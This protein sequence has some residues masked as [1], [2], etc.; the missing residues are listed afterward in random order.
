MIQTDLCSYLEV[1]VARVT[2]TTLI[3]SH[4]N[5]PQ[6]T[7][8]SSTCSRT[9]VNSCV[10]TVNCATLQ[11]ALCIS[12]GGK[13]HDA[14]AVAC[15]V[16]EVLYEDVS[17]MSHVLMVTLHRSVTAKLILN[18]ETA[19]IDPSIHRSIQPSIHPSINQNVSL[20]TALYQSFYRCLL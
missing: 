17:Q 16:A 6:S 9:E 3:N 13:Q 7:E 14:A 18:L 5:I 15:T 10:D 19:T 1:T 12:V 2:I 11:E 4:Y 20:H 8:K